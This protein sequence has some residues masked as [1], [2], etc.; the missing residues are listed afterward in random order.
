LQQSNLNANE[1]LQT[2]NMQ[3]EDRN[4]LEEVLQLIKIGEAL[5]ALSLKAVLDSLR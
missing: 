4:K 5:K 3:E 2:V 1:A